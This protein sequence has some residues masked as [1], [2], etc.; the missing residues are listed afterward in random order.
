MQ[1]SLIFLW[2][3]DFSVENNNHLFICIE[4]DI[5]SILKKCLKYRLKFYPSDSFVMILILN[6]PILKQGTILY[7]INRVDTQLWILWNLKNPGIICGE[8]CKF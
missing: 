4:G 3:I 7:V 5:T 8:P 2:F 6:N 1:G